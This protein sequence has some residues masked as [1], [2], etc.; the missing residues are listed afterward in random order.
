MYD[1]DDDEDDDKPCNH[2]YNQ[3]LTDNIWKSQQ[4]TC[5]FDKTK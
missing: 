3:I 1:D 4:V 2:W 5:M